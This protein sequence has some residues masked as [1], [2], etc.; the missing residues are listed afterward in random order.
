MVERD[1]LSAWSAQTQA[2]APLAAPGPPGSSAKGERHRPHSRRGPREASSLDSAPW[3]SPSSSKRCCGRAPS[4]YEAEAARVWPD[5]AA[6]YGEVTSDVLG[7]SYVRVPGG[8][9]PT[10]AMLGHITRSA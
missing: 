9:A 4:G 7:S 1:G 6:A 3:R 10:L 5:A 8:D 2:P